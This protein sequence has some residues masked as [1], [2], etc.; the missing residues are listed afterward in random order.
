M[1]LL[2]QQSDLLEYAGAGEWR[3]LG[4]G[5]ILAGLA[6]GVIPLVI[7][8]GNRQPMVLIPAALGILLLLGGVW[9]ASF[10]ES[11]VFDGGATVLRVTT[12]SL[13]SSSADDIPF[14]KID[15]VVLGARVYTSAS[16]QTA[17]HMYYMELRLDDGRAIKLEDSGRN[18]DER[19]AKERASEIAALCGA[20]LLTETP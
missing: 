14:A 13:F 19:L 11:M 1:R 4:A 8:L 2:R 9:A 20:E 18:K 10:R 12:R 15:G 17:R 16:G 7:F 5:L 3:I 6:F